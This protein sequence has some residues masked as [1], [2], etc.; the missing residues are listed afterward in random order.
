MRTT[1]T[2]RSWGALL[3]GIF[4]A[5][6]TCRTIFDDVWNGAAINTG[7]LQSAAAIIAA[8]A[9]GHMIWPQLKQANIAAALSLALIFTAGTG[10]V[11]ISAGARNAETMQAKASTIEANN[12]R[13]TEA[14][15]KLAT[16]EAE[17][18]AAKETAKAAN[19][20]A[21][22]ECASGKKSKCDGRIETR[23]AAADA[24]ELA[25][26]RA[27]VA[28]AY[29]DL[30]KPVTNAHGGYA[31]AAHVLAALPFV[32]AKAEAIQTSLE[33]LMPFIT[34]M[35]SEI[36]TLTFLGMA[37]G[38][39]QTTA[40][41]AAN[42]PTFSRPAAPR[43]PKGGRKVKRLPENVSANVVPFSGKPAAIEALEKVGRPV[44]NRELA[45]L[46]GVT[47]GEASK[48][49]K[50]LGN[51]VNVQRNGKALMISLASFR[52]VA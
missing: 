36:G 38:H 33:L 48:R 50:E 21:A 25:E 10:Y 23:N 40:K 44:S 8:I 11:V 47:D 4:L 7:H 27:G 17:L 12:E 37:L 52:Q 16:A 13:H 14:T 35:I 1:T 2:I 41:V 30:T 3:L 31:H 15:A 49:V 32:T 19:E 24:L 29:L 18:E 46:M 22:K 6:V 9:A 51:L 39:R 26:H 28:K 5:A 43:P 34:V 45:K 20:A 42:V